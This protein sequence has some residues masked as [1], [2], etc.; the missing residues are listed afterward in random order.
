MKLIFLAAPFR[1]ATD[2]E[3]WCN[4]HRAETT[5]LQVWRLGACAICPQA[6]SAHFHGEGP[7]ELYLRGYLALLARCDA[8]LIAGPRSPGVVAEIEEAERLKI[9]VLRDIESLD[10]WL[11]KQEAPLFA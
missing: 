1:A 10:A 5:A 2:W 9:P 4:V 6:N 11:K 3:R 7:D 8:V